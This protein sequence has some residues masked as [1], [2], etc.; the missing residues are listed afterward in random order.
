M[1]PI[2]YTDQIIREFKSVGYW[3]DE[4]F[5]DFW[6]K[7]AKERPEREAL[8]D[9]NMRITWA[10]AAKIMDR[11]ALAWID[12]G[13][14][15]DDR[16]ILQAPNCA[17]G[18]LARIACE[19]AGLINITVMPYLRH[20]E[21]THI[22]EK[23]DP[24]AIIVPGIYRKFNY[25]EMIEELKKDHPNLKY[26][27]LLDSTI[28]GPY[29]EG[30]RSLIDIAEE[31][32]ENKTDVSVL[33]KR[34]FHATEDVGALT[35]TSGTTGV[36]KIVEWPLASRV[37]T[38]KCRVEIWKLTGEDTAMAVAP[39]AGGAAGTL[40]YFAAPLVGSKIV[41]LEE[42]TPEGAL[43]MIQ[44]ERVTC[45]GVVPTHIIRMLECDLSKYDLSSLRFIRSAGGYL[46]PKVAMEAEERLGGKITSDLGTQ[47]VG[48]VS[49]CSIDD[50]GDVRRRTVG[51][52]LR[53]NVIK[54]RDENGN[55]VP[56]G[57]PGILYMRGPHSPAGYWRDPETTREVFD[58]NN[59]TTTGDIVTLEEGRIWIMGR[60]KDVIIRGG[61]NIYPAEIEGLL[62][63][64]PKVA[65]I[66]IV[67]MPDREFGEKACAYVVPKT[68]ETF[69]FEDMAA[70]LKAKKL[71]MY[72]LPER[73]E[74]IDAMPTVG[75]SGKVDKKVL[76]K[77]I[78]DKVS[79]EG[80]A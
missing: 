51:K 60:Q 5:T 32:W 47:D 53:G 48:S 65:S 57:D 16:V 67:A 66:A 45:I 63:E 69:V 1:K 41:L 64:H 22:I 26:A 3:T 77:D 74:I 18:F 37:M 70:F 19:R 56:P 17:Y 46:P 6:M 30:V 68:G 55:E 9:S 8:V 73:L 36:P 20:K 28:S 13:L 75:D 78:E 61:Q 11:F 58:D 59:W 12:M 49:G 29:P 38:S 72:K 23:I 62:N 34:R 14:N 27:F 42:F 7:N 25:L 79:S 80:K 44:K 31:P 40:T 21:L 15:K 4:T 39:F 24:R 2:R 76:K 43:E 52:P 71:A 33:D 54:L 10:Q 50:P 35:S